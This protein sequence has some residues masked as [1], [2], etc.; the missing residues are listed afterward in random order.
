VGRS[1]FSIRFRPAAFM[2]EDDAQDPSVPGIV[3]IERD[4]P[5]GF[6]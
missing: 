2:S 1:E 5:L 4:G 6:I 3:G